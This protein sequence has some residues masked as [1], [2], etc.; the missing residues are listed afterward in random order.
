MEV[1][2]DLVTWG[3]SAMFGGGMALRVVKTQIKNTMTYET[4]RQICSKERIER[5]RMLDKLFD[6]Q[7][8]T[9]GLIKELHGHIKAKNG[10]NFS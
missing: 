1:S 6:A 3:V 5:N 2:S 7:K 9:Y 8:E 10:G 4:H